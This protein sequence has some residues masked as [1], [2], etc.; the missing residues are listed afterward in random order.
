M[1][2]ARNDL[3]TQFVSAPV[4]SPLWYGTKPF[5]T[6]P[7]KYPEGIFLCRDSLDLGQIDQPEV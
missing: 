5:T 1:G 6:E 2:V 7:L 3:Q 4:H